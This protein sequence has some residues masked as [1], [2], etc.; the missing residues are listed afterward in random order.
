MI[1]MCS[2]LLSVFFTK[3]TMPYKL[4]TRYF[5]HESD[6]LPLRP[7][8]LIIRKQARKCLLGLCLAVN[9]VIRRLLVRLLLYAGNRTSLMTYLTASLT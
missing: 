3:I 8:Y 1:L 6:F 5:D 9:Y 2:G 4:N 7:L